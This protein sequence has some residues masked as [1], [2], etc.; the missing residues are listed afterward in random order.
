M[1]HK[2]KALSLC[3]ALTLVTFFSLTACGSQAVFDAAGYTKSC[4]DAAIKADFGAYVQN[5]G[6]T[7]EEAQNDFQE[8]LEFDLSEMMGDLEMSAEMKDSYCDLLARIY[9]NCRYEVGAATK[10]GDDSFTVPVTTQKM[11]VFKGCAE[12]AEKKLMTYVATAD[13]T[14]S[15][16]Q[17]TEKYLNDLLNILSKNLE[18]AEFEEAQ[19]ISVNVVKS[20][21][22][23]DK[24]EIPAEEYTKIYV[25]LM[26]MDEMIESSD[27]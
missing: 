1:K 8:T 14:P 7:L 18:K 5:T 27:E 3:I 6:I 15:D 11:I 19:T 9:A 23:E 4:L 13:K 2:V 10:N 22:E 26:D 24:Y 16:T 17:I 12:A 25:A 21:T 20:S